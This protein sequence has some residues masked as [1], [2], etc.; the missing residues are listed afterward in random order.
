M[1]KLIAIMIIPVLIFACTLTDENDAS[2]TLS[3]QGIKTQQLATMPAAS[4]TPSPISSCHVQT[5]VDN[6]R[7]NLRAGPGTQYPVILILHE[8]DVFTAST[9]TPS[10]D[11]I[12]AET[13]DHHEG[14]INSHF[15]QCNN[16]QGGL[17]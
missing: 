3:T 11:W 13:N 10:H 4:P 5:N 16:S 2:V 7:L 17:Q 8:G 14:W 15:V 6:G 9:S 1:K 12:F